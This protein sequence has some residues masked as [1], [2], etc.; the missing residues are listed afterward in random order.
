MKD[1]NLK[2]DSEYGFLQIDPTPSKDEIAAYYAEE[3][4]ASENPAQ[5]NDSSLD[6]QERDKQFYDSWRTDIRLI[7]E[8]EIKKDNISIYDFGCGWCESLTY[9]NQFGYECFGIDTAPEAIEHGKNKGFNVEVS[10]L[11]DINPF[12]RRFDVVMMQNVLEHLAS[13]KETVKKIYNDVL[14]YG[15]LLIIDVPNEFNIF[16]TVGCEVNNLSEWWV[17]PPAHLN[18]FSVST[19]RALLIG[20]GF[21]IVE[22]LASF[23]LEMFLLMGDNYVGNPELGRVCHVKRMQFEDSLRKTGK[24]AVLHELYRNFAKQNLGRQILMIA[25]KG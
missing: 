9:F 4:Y 22:E 15:G 6:V 10:D 20:E 2:P 17:A 24:T 12:E 8:S 19:L 3:F 14:A 16:Q 23:P 18:Y 1:Y 7:I 13:P 25:K 5:V 21:S 11:V